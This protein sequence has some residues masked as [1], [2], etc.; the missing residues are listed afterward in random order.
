MA[1]LVCT[2]FAN[3]ALAW[4][5]ANNAAPHPSGPH[6]SHGWGGPI[7][8]PSWGHLHTP[9]MQRHG[10]LGDDTDTDGTPPRP[11]LRSPSKRNRSMSPIKYAR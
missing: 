10:L 1:F 5:P 2:L 7:D 9:K 6:P 4:K 11:L 8:D 3:N